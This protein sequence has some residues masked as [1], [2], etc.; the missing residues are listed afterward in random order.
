MKKYCHLLNKVNRS[1]CYSSARGETLNEHRH[2]DIWVFLDKMKKLS[3][4]AA[5]IC[6]NLLQSAKHWK[7]YCYLVLV[8]LN[9]VNRRSCRSPAH[10]ETLN[11]HRY[12]NIWVF[13]DKMKELSFCAA[14]ICWG[15][16]QSAKYWKRQCYLVVVLLDKMNRRS[17]RSSARRE[18]LNKHCHLDVWVLL[19][20][21]N[22]LNS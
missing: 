17:Y 22:K 11:E 9:K 10:R 6:W 5:E 21:V 18:T 4:W 13:L 16:L 2:L 3:F 7:R 8:L 19:D 15:L 1:I 12:L 20:E 14:E